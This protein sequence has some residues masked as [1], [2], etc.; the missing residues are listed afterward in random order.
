MRHLHG[1][2]VGL[3]RDLP[4]DAWDR[5]TSAPRWR[6]RDVAAH[7]LD[8]DLRRLAFHRDGLPLLSPPEPIRSYR[9]LVGFLDGLNAT[10]VEASRRLSPRLLVEL[11]EWSG[12]RLADFVEALDPDARAFLEVVWAGAGPTPNWMDIG[13]EFTERWHHQDQIREAVGAPPLA[14]AGWLRPVLEIS[15][16]GLPPAWAGVAAGEG[17]AVVVE[18][19]GEVRGSWTLWRGTASNPTPDAGPGS[20]GWRLLAGAAVDPAARVRVGALP[21]ARL[22]LHRLAPAQARSALRLEGEAELVE[23]IFRA[24]AVMV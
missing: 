22:L 13:R 10:W 2:L 15:V 12:T 16:R 6:V 19:T 4:A 9:D 8:G 20:G 21:L 18:S 1:E 3:L 5:R 7:L 23:P 17:T 14:D 11:L 24:R